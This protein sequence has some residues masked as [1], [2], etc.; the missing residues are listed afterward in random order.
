MDSKNYLIDSI[1]EW[2]QLDSDMRECQADMRSMRK[3]KNEL[4][5]V[6]V[7]VMK[8][9][10]ID[11]FDINNG[12]LIYSQYK[13]TAPLSKKHLLNSLGNLFSGDPEKIE[14]IS[15]HILNSR[16]VKVKEKIRRKIENNS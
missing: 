8:D 16:E 14:Q 10:E 3:R 2:I 13:Y 15:N 7:D 6:L 11:V 4:T 9:K 5:N 1:K 12:K